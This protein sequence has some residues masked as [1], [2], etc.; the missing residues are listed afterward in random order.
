MTQRNNKLQPFR[1]TDITGGNP[2]SKSFYWVQYSHRVGQIQAVRFE[3]VTYL[4]FPDLAAAHGFFRWV[5]D[6]HS[7]RCQV[8]K[9]KRFSY[10]FEA[11]LRKLMLRDCIRQ[12][13]DQLRLA[14][15][16]LYRI[17]VLKLLEVSYKNLLFKFS[18][19]RNL[20]KKI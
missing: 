20:D 7:L 9:A 15:A 1:V 3:T 5:T 19:E 8:R 11:P 16:A 6:N 18:K 4:Q 13:A 14:E 12:I 2:E 17:V 10:G